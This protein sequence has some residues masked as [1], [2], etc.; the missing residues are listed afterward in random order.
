MVL[1]DAQRR[2]IELNKAAAEER[3]RKAVAEKS[4]SNINTT[5]GAGGALGDCVEQHKVCQKCDSSDILPMYW[6]TFGE[7]ICKKCAASD[8]DW[9]VMNKT[10]VVTEYLLPDDT[11]RH[12]RHK[13]KDNPHRKGWSEMKLFLRRHARLESYRRWGGEEELLAEISRRKGQKLERELSRAKDTSDSGINGISVEASG[14]ASSILARMLEQGDILS[15]N[16]NLK[17]RHELS[18]PVSDRTSSDLPTPVLV[19]EKRIKSRDDVKGKT[20]KR[21]LTPHIASMLSAIRGK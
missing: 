3:R 1:S 8:T 9:E 14:E 10:S 2:T 11:I 13:T 5:I 15:A 4:D 18:D 7:K 17:R 6:E 20:P 16:Q 19:G 12:L 21:S